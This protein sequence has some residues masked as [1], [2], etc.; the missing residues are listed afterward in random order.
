MP[1]HTGACLWRTSCTCGLCPACAQQEQQLLAFSLPAL[2]AGCAS[3]F[4]YVVLGVLLSSFNWIDA[5]RWVLVGCAVLMW[6]ASFPP[7]HNSQ[8]LSTKLLKLNPFNN[9]LKQSCRSKD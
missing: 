7:R 9:T 5:Y 4:G 6:S 8:P 2:A 1:G 3:L